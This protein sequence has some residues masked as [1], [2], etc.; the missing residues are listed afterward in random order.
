MAFCST[1]LLVLQLLS[2][3]HGWLIQAKAPPGFN[4]ISKA[5]LEGTGGYP[6][7]SGG[8]SNRGVVKPVTSMPEKHAGRRRDASVTRS[9]S[10][11]DIR[12]MSDDELSQLYQ[13]VATMDD[14]DLQGMID[15]LTEELGLLG[16]DEKIR[17]LLEDADGNKVANNT[18]AAALIS[19][20]HRDVTQAYETFVRVFSDT[21]ARKKLDEILVPGREALRAQSTSTI[22][23]AVA[24]PGITPPDLPAELLHTPA[25]DTSSNLKALGLT[26]FATLLSAQA[27]PVLKNAEAIPI[28][29]SLMSAVRFDVAALLL[30][31]YALASGGEAKYIFRCMLPGVFSLIANGGQ[32]LA[33]QSMSVG[34]TAIFASMQSVMTPLFSRFIVG[35]P[36]KLG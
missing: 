33:V 27:Y 29:L 16:D 11:N 6:K 1:L 32:I 23:G 9:F 18:L 30:V 20:D 28:P 17:E 26:V 19:G 34:E 25:A 14:D 15:S 8:I 36:I 2:T 21:A 10:F 7:R 3:C 12:Q 24:T 22:A 31:P 4:V 13:E 5:R 35:T